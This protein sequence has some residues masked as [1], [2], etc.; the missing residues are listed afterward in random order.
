MRFNEGDAMADQ[1]VRGTWWVLVMGFI[2][3]AGIGGIYL[4]YW[5]LGEAL[6]GRWIV[7]V[8]GGVS[9]TALGCVTILACRH[10]TDLLYS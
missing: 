10:R 2:A 8:V 5:G 1:F 7:G 3:A 4:G 6:A 9:A